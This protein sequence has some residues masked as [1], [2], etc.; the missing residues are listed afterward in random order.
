MACPARRAAGRAAACDPRILLRARVDGLQD[1]GAGV[2]RSGCRQGHRR[3]SPRRAAVVVAG[4]D[5][6]GRGGGGDRR[7]A[8]L[9]GLQH[10]LPGRDRHAAAALRAP[11]AAAF[12]VPRPGADRP[13]PRPFGIRPPAD[14]QLQHDDPHHDR[15]RDDRQRGHGDPARHQLAPRHPDPRRAAVRARRRP[16]V[17]D[18]DPPGVAGAAG[19]AGGAVG[20][21]RGDGERRARRQGVR[22]RRRVLRPHAGPRRRRVRPGDGGRARARPTTFRLSTSCPLSA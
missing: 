15:Q 1:P 3:R 6:S 9:P 18:Q 22:R 2:G 21:G 17:R 11:A 20:A 8:A 19:G 16:T 12:R 13:A 5:R 10:R 14:Q 7:V 4:A